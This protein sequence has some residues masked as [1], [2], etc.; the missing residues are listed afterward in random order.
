MPVHLAGTTDPGDIEPTRRPVSGQLPSA[1]PRSLLRCRE[2]DVSFRP[3]PTRLLRNRGA[4]VPPSEVQLSRCLSGPVRPRFLLL[5]NAHRQPWDYYLA[6]Q[7]RDRDG[8]RLRP[9]RQPAR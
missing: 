6:V 9:T 4:S 3:D 2:L 5:D 1:T 7:W 8:H